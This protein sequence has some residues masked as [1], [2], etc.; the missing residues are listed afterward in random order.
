MQ[1]ENPCNV[2]KLQSHEPALSSL[3]RDSEGNPF[4]ADVNVF[5]LYKQGKQTKLGIFHLF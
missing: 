5:S 3:W 2:S 4:L 1:N